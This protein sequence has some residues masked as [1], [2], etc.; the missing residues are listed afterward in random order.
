[1]F[2]A[3]GRKEEK[4]MSPWVQETTYIKYMDTLFEHVHQS[5]GKTP[6]QGPSSTPIV[7][8]P[9]SLPLPTVTE[10][11][12]LKKQTNKKTKPKVGTVAH[13][14]ASVLGRLG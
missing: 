10:M 2:L 14:F 11:S 12:G 6:R 3:L 13:I 4:Y 7:L 8:S 5:H 9:Y 1:M